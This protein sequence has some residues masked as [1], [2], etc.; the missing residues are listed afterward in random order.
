MGKLLSLAKRRRETDTQVVN[1]IRLAK[2]A[3]TSDHFV[4]PTLKAAA[5]QSRPLLTCGLAEKDFS[6]LCCENT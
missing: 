6:E 3:D 1:M 2:A 4:M 5:A